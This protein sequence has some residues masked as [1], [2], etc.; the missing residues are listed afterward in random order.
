MKYCPKCNRAYNDDSQSFCLMDGTPLVSRNEVETVV[1]PK[2]TAKRKSRW[3]LWLALAVVVVIGG[4]STLGL[5]IYKFSRA[6]ETAQTKRPSVTNISASPSPAAKIS[7]TV[8]AST[9]TPAVEEDSPK[10][11]KSTVPASNEDADDVTPIAWE[12]TASGFKSDENL[13]YKF[14]CPEH[15]TEHTVWGSDVYTQDSSICTAA[16]HAG[17]IT[18]ADGGIVTIEFRPGRL[19]YGSTVRN[20]IKT[21][22]YGEYPHSFVV[23]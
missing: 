20:G 11:S 16:V 23:H 17:V 1:I 18:L 12:T 6:N 8:A 9:N 2:P 15:G 14:R 4:I 5:L 22:T 19:T 21:S 13:V 7:P 3:K 10:P